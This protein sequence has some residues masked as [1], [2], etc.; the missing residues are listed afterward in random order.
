MLPHSYHSSEKSLAM[1]TRVRQDGMNMSSRRQSTPFT[2]T[3]AIISPLHCHTF[4]KEFSLGT[5]EKRHWTPFLY[6]TLSTQ[7]YIA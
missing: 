7:Q 3:L 5:T 1:V 6:V 4:P 2:Q